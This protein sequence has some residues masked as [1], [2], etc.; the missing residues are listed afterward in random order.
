MTP[1]SVLVHVPNVPKGLEWY[2]KAFPEATPIIIQSLI[3][4]Y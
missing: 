3:S 1:V 4:R 2:Q